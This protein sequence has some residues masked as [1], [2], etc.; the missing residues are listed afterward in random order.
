MMLLQ[1]RTTKVVLFGALLLFGI[2]FLA[3]CGFASEV[4][5]MNPSF[6]TLPSGGLNHPCPG[7]NCEF[8]LG[9]IPGWT[10]PGGTTNT[11]QFRPS[12]SGHGHIFDTFAPNNGEISA[13]SNG[14]TISQTLGTTV[15]AGLDYTFTVDLGHRNDQSFG[16]SADLLLSGGPHHPQ[17][18]VAMGKTPVGGHWSTFTA[19]FTGNSSNV[20]DLITI[21][22]NSHGGQGNFDSVSLTAVPEP[23]TMLLFGSGLLLL[24]SIIIVR[25]KQMY[26]RELST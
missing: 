1:A 18:I 22:L 8:S 5:V 16:S 11:G 26:G 17:T 10:V 23:G 12:I 20:G 25:R 4:P 24:F 9:G 13:F 21:Q 6:E 7:N 3:P 15:Q 14:P 2:A 19:T